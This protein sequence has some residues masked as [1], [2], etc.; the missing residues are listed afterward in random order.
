ME[1]HERAIELMTHQ[2]TE[3]RLEPVRAEIAELQ[4]AYHAL[5]RDATANPRTGPT[6]TEARKMKRALADAERRLESALQELRDSTQT[7]RAEQRAELNA[8]LGPAAAVARE[9]IRRRW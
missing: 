6:T 4:A 7:L 1:E 8:A 5:L 9:P 3:E 2:F